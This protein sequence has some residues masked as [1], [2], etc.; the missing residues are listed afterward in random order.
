[1]KILKKI[2]DALNC[3]RREADRLEKALEKANAESKWAEFEQGDT[4]RGLRF[5]LSAIEK[6]QSKDRQP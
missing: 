4:A 5:D 1:M 2:I 3:E 6:A